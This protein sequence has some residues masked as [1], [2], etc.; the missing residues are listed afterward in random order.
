MPAGTVWE[1]GN[2]AG[3]LVAP[4]EYE[5]VVRGWKM[6]RPFGRVGL[7]LR[8]ELLSG[9]H[10]DGIATPYEDRTYSPPKRYQ[11]PE[12]VTLAANFNIKPMNGGFRPGR[13]SKYIRA[14]AAVFDGRLPA[15]PNPDC[16]KDRPVRCLVTTV[17]TDSN[18]NPLH[19]SCWYST[20]STLIGPGYGTADSQGF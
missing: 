5:A 18:G 8:V 17:Q 11:A 20:V 9:P 14:I 19:P 13:K 12:G 6:T 4:G 16:L 15:D 1:Y 2:E 10:N 7:S 3:P